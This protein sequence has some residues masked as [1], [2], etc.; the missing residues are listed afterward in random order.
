MTQKP[1]DLQKPKSTQKP[2]VNFRYLFR[3]IVQG[4]SEARWDDKNLFIKHLS[5]LDQVELEELDEKYFQIA[6]DRGLP[7]L[8]DTEKR[9]QEEGLWSKADQGK[10]KEQELYVESLENTRKQLYLKSEIENNISQIKEAQIKL[11]QLKRKKDDLVGHTCEKYAAG[12]LNDFYILRSFYEDE[13]FKAP[14]FDD[15]SLDELTKSEMHELIYLYNV[16]IGGLNDEN[17]QKIILQDFY[18]PYYPFA[19]NVMNFYNKPLFYLSLLQVK[20]IVFTR[21]FKNIFETHSKIP[22]NIR[23]EPDKIIDWVNAQDKAKEAL[24]TLD[25]DG[26][27]TIIGAKEEDYEYL[28]YKQNPQGR[29]LSEMLKKKGGRMNMKDLMETMT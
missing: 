8:E 4:F 20:L 5:T 27:S 16:K 15:E 17:V 25:K 2:K 11:F 12:K 18:Q 22:E 3:D 13:Q 29:S 28:G 6:K 10:I 7:T 21:M 19:E 23:Q 24:E 9:L 14:L 26:A 1:K